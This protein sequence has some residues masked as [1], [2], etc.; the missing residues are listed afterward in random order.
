MANKL[1]VICENGLVQDIICTEPMEAIVIDFDDIDPD[2]P[3]YVALVTKT[4]NGTDIIDE[5][6]AEEYDVAVDAE[7]VEEI[8]EQVLGEEI[9]GDEEPD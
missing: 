5:V 2:D 4:K 3:R 9:A 7:L 6:W 1:L 8:F